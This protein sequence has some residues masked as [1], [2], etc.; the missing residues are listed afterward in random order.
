MIENSGFEK[1]NQRIEPNP[2]FIKKEI[3]KSLWQEIPVSNFGSQSLFVETKK[4]FLSKI[5][6]KLI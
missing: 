2:D 5:F 4:M 1:K 3:E 6:I